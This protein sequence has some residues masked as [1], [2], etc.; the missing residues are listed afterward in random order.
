MVGGGGGEE[1][2][3]RV[4]RWASAGDEGGLH[5]ARLEDREIEQLLCRMFNPQNSS[6]DWTKLPEEFRYSDH[7]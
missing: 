4:K 3:P 2:G 1:K 5:T 7:I 6:H